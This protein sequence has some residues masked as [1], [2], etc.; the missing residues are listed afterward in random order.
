MFYNFKLLVIYNL[1]ST[2]LILAPVAPVA[3]V[4]TRPQQYPVPKPRTVSRMFHLPD[5]AVSVQIIHPVYFQCPVVRYVPE[6][7]CF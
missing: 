7:D 2:F 6:P 4:I 1:L 5:I 3:A